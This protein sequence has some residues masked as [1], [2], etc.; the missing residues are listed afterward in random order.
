VANVAL[1]LR[2]VRSVLDKPWYRGAER[3]PSWEEVLGGATT[4]GEF[5]EARADEDLQQIPDGRQVML[6]W[7]TD[8]RGETLRW[9][10]DASLDAEKALGGSYFESL[11]RGEARGT[12]YAGEMIRDGQRAEVW[13][14]RP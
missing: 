6:M 12:P 3:K 7:M 5:G 10:V 13:S 14:R 4:S 11:E 2:E 9:L 1:E 8:S